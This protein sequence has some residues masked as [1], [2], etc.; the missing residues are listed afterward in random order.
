MDT[1][2]SSASQAPDAGVVAAVE[3][4]VTANAVISIPESQGM[5][6]D[7]EVVD[8]RRRKLKS[9]V[10]KEFTRIQTNGVWKAECMW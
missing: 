2:S 10:W 9:V 8:G 5:D 3:A 7:V 4:G 6:T 1:P